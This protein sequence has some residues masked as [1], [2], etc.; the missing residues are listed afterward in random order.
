MKKVSV[1]EGTSGPWEVSRFEVNE[2]QAMMDMLKNPRRHCPKGQYTQ[3][4]RD[5]RIVMSDT[6]AEMR[7][8]HWAVREAQGHILINGLGLGLVLLNCMSKP[9]VERATVIELSPDVIRLVGPHY[10]EM[11]GDRLE[12]ICADAMT[13]KAPKGIKFGMVWHDIWPDI[14]ADNYEAMKTLHRRYGRKAEHQGSWCREEV[15]GLVRKKA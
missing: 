1:P 10:E 5:G 4:T 13:W 6:P 8:H 12:I 3:L 15:E 14:S 9:E 7:D 2:S 11:Y